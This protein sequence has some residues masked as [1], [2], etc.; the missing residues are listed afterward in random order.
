LQQRRAHRRKTPGKT[1]VKQGV[2][3]RGIRHSGVVTALIALTMLSANARVVEGQSDNRVHNYV[4]S[5]V[6][7]GALLSIGASAVIDQAQTDP[8]E[9]GNG[10]SGFGKRVASAAGA[11]FA[12]ETVRHGLAAVLDRS[13]SYERCGCKSFGARLG[14]AV[15]GAITDRN[16]EGRTFLSEPAIAG[17][18]AGAYAPR[19]WRP[20]YT[21]H[22]ALAGVGISLGLSALGNVVHEFILH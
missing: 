1:T 13:T 3:M 16:E 19:I 18:V 11:R 5:L 12:N 21:S 15:I 4:V 20:S 6:G 22:D 14:H 8:A 17:A 2:G 7:P 9:W 10:A